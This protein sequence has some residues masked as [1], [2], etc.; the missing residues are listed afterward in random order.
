MSDV[1]LVCEGG[2]LHAHKLLLTLRS[3]ML[4][5]M[6]QN[7]MLESQNKSVEC[8]FIYDIMK[9]LLEYIYIGKVNDC[10]VHELFVAADFYGLSTLKSICEQMLLNN[11]I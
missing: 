9:D 2:T 4:E 1:T 11:L 6:F 8:T 7:D 3:E 10:N 5:R